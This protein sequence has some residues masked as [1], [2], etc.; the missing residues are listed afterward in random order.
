MKE[1]LIAGAI[2]LALT[3]SSSSA[4]ATHCVVRTYGCSCANTGGVPAL[5]PGF[6]KGAYDHLYVKQGMFLRASLLRVIEVDSLGHPVPDSVRGLSEWM[7]H[8][9]R[10]ERAWR[11]VGGPV[12][13]DTVRFVNYSSSMCP[14]PKWHVGG[15]YLLFAFRH[16]GRLQTFVDCQ[17]EH[18][19]E[20]PEAQ[21]SFVLLDSLLPRR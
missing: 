17:R 16:R 3:L 18:P 11:R 6:A 21:R 13:P 10:V 12:P 7:A 20:L 2:A 8:D 9:F 15:S 1:R 4:T 5:I 19:S 14:R